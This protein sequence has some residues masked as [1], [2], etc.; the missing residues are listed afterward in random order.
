MEIHFDII[1]KYKTVFECLRTLFHYG[2]TLRLV[3]TSSSRTHD[4]MLTYY[5]LVSPIH[6][7]IP[8]FLVN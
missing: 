2:M 8:I 7:M 1:A 3:T 5:L 6:L 4:T